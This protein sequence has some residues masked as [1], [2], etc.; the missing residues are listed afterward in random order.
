MWAKKNNIDVG[1]SVEERI[2]KNISNRKTIAQQQQAHI[3]RNKQNF[4]IL[5]DIPRENRAI[6]KID[7]QIMSF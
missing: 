4:I 6:I 5:R 3:N 2:N 1:P 7:F